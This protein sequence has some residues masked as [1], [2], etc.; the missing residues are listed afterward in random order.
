M[1]ERAYSVEE[2]AQ[3]LGISALQ[4]WELI[5]QGHIPVVKFGRRTVVPRWA[6]ERR[7]GTPSPEKEEM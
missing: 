5:H 4:M 6:L 1:T 3:A 7:L 2:A